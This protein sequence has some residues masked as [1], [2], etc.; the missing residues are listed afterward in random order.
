[1][2]TNQKPSARILRYVKKDAGLRLQ[3][4]ENMAK[5][6]INE[7]NCKGCEMCVN[8]CP[9][10]LLKLSDHINGKGYHPV[11]MTDEAACIGCKS[12]AL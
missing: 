11:M 1:M 12:C 5:L 2:F 9:K 3:E 10:Q 4:G 6:I 7:T 8:A